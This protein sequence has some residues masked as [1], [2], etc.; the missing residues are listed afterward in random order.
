MTDS[1]NRGIVLAQA[2]VTVPP[3]DPRTQQAKQ[4]LAPVSLT[5]T[6][7]RVAIIGANGSGKSTLLRLL[8]GLLLPTTGTVTVNGRSTHSDV[9]AVRRSVGFVF[10]D[11]LSQL[12]MP[13]PQED[14]ELSLRRQKLG[15]KERR[16]KALAILASYGLE[17]LAQ[18]SIYE[19]SGGERQLTA[20]ATVLAVDPDILVLDEPSTLLDLRNTRQLMQRLNGL[21][22]QVIMSTHDLS[23]AATFDRAL[24]I[25][26]GQVAF[27][28]DPHQ[29]IAAYQE[30]AG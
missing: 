15:K 27:D 16:D 13:T 26:Q 10:T 20:L 25:D 28:G 7:Q 29:A 17:H 8:N 22:Q 30:M 12:V 14:L 5:L 23:L 1:S 21:P 6:E 2:G 9:A 19:L 3:A 18:S 4:I 11:P 24:V